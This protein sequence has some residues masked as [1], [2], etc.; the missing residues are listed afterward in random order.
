MLTL[1][2]LD[3][4]V[5]GSATWWVSSVS[6]QER[7][8]QAAHFGAGSPAHISVVTLTFSRSDHSRFPWTLVLRREAWI[9][10]KLQVG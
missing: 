6:L 2:A 10:V 8:S 1:P 3:W 5:S 4:T 9:T 7:L